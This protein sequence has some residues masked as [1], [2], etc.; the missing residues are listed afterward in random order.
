MGKLTK[1]QAQLLADICHHVQYVAENYAPAKKLVALGYAEW[2][3]LRYGT[4]LDPTP[5]GRSALKGPDHG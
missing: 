4:T 5:A 1:A 3:E 2:R